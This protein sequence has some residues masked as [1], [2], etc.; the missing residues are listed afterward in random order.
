MRVR[1]RGARGE[2]VVK[3]E[4]KG[5]DARGGRQERRE[6]PVP[7]PTLLPHTKKVDLAPSRHAPAPTPPPP[8][9][10]TRY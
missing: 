10:P 7:Q 4:M 3:G 9:S 1:A 6:H 5:W 2:T 8:F